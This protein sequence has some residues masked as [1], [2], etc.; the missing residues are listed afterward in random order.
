MIE[1]LNQNA[2][3]QEG[4]IKYQANQLAKLIMKFNE[5]SKSVKNAVQEK[6]VEIGQLKTTINDNN[7]VMGPLKRKISIL[8]SQ[9]ETLCD[10]ISKKVVEIATLK[11]DL[12]EKDRQ[13]SEYMEKLEQSSAE[14]CLPFGNSTHLHAIKI[15]GMEPFLAPCDSRFA[16][17][18]WMVI[19]RRIDGR[20]DFNRKWKDYK[21]GFGNVNGEFW[22]GL[23]RIH[24]MT[25][26]RRYELYV[27]LVSIP[28]NCFLYARYDKFEIGSEAE[29]YK[30]KLLGKYSGTANDNL[31]YHEEMAFTTID[32]D[33][34]K[35]KYM[36]LASYFGG[37]WWHN[38]DEYRCV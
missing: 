10:E 22:L 17:P 21:Y 4:V 36:N 35:A 11:C 19:Q 5:Y 3:K 32:R 18:G 33:N 16:G 26:S 31:S 27:H 20:I 24:R 7:S 14:D 9:S 13:I 6:E 30:L 1:E 28:N 29:K 25:T 34:D 15:R 12:E 23:E 8:E 38:I 37:A 2:V